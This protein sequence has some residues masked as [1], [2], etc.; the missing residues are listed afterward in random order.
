VGKE[1]ACNALDTGSVGL[2]SGL[3]R[4]RGGRKW[5]PTPAF[6]PEKSHGGNL[7]GYSPKVAK[8]WIRLNN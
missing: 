7:V 6:L 5:Q 8:I 3:G 4:P 1:S 2:I